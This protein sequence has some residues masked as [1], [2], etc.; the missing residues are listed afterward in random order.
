MVRVVKNTVDAVR[1]IE[2]KKI[3]CDK[4][5]NFCS[6]AQL[7]VDCESGF[8]PS[9]INYEDAKITGYNSWGLFMHNEPYFEGWDDPIISTAKAWDK[10]QRRN[11]QPWLNCS[12]RLGLLF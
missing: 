9:S 1:L 2:I 3:I 10:F 8:N 4:F 6:Q 5:G 12:R 11:W 7:I